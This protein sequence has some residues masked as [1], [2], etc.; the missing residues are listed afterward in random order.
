MMLLE[1]IA[2]WKKKEFEDDALQNEPGYFLYRLLTGAA[3]SALLTVA[4]GQMLIMAW[5]YITDAPKQDK[6]AVHTE[7]VVKQK[8][9]VAWSVREKLSHG[10]GHF[11]MPAPGPLSSPFGMRWGRMH[12]GI[13]IASPIGTPV[14]AADNGRVIFAGVKT[15][16]GNCMIIDHGNGYETVYGH[17]DALVAS[18]GDIVEKK[19]LI[20]YSGNTGRSTGPHLHFEI[21][22]HGEPIDPIPFLQ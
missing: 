4:C 17:L 9:Q 13:D 19:E 12:Q 20:A 21:R 3:T 2:S 1:R 22:E 11:L 7:Q 5:P 18:E 15:G 14:K 10:D 6:Q 8:E 16:Y